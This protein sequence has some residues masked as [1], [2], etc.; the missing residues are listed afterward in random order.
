MDKIKKEG[1][2]MVT[3]F[4]KVLRIIRI[5]TGDSAK[6]MAGKLGISVPYLNAIENGRRDVPSNLAD[7]VISVY[8]L[9]E[10]DKETLRESLIQ[11]KDRVKIDLTE[12]A[13]K[14]RKIIMALA[15]NEV[16]ETTLDEIVKMVNSQK[17]E[18]Q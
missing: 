7:K 9:S 11:S 1:R 6:E 17:G 2:T 3:E 8:E 12:L 15:R 18:S 5:S 14:Q 10:K 4:G 13:E 16:D